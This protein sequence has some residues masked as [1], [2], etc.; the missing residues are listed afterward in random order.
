MTGPARE[1]PTA[2]SRALRWGA[3]LVWAATV[4]TLSS[5]SDP[6]GDLRFPWE[7]P[8]KLVHG[9]E[10]AVGGAL[11]AAAFRTTALRSP[12]LAAVVAC[13]VWGCVDEIHQG[14]VPG[15]S[16]EAG[17]LIADVTGA[18]LG[19]ILLSVVANR[20]SRRARP[21]R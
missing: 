2:A 19:A 14:F 10:F 11:A 12:A 5:R 21:S 13:A 4:W 20:P 1:P 9:L 16:T 17:D 3:L 7:V 6:K 8:D 15:R 18:A